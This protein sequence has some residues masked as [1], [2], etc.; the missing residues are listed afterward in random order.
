M[1]RPLQEAMYI[2]Y[3]TLHY[4]QGDMQH[5]HMLAHLHDKQLHLPPSHNIKT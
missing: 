1:V 4:K 2:N 3:C 5:V